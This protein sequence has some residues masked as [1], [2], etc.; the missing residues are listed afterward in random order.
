M[1][2]R[3][4][5]QGGL[6]QRRAV[7]QLSAAAL[8][9][10]VVGFGAFHRVDPAPP[11]QLHSTPRRPA[12]PQ[13][14][15]VAG[16]TA[17]ATP[18]PPAPSRDGG[19]G[20]DDDGDPGG[21]GGATAADT[22]GG[23]RCRITASGAECSALGE[24]YSMDFTRCSSELRLRSGMPVESVTSI[25]HGIY[26]VVVPSGGQFAFKTECRP[27]AKWH[28]QQGWPEVAVHQL[29][30]ALL[31]GND[32]VPCAA[33][34]V[35]RLDDRQLS[36]LHSDR[37]GVVADK[38]GMVAGV[39]M[40]W[41]TH[42]D[43]ALSSPEVKN[44]WKLFAPKDNKRIS[45]S[46]RRLA[47]QMGLVLALDFLVHNPDREEKNWFWG[48]GGSRRLLTMD[49]GWAFV[50][51]GYAGS[52]CDSAQESYLSCP[53]VIRHTARLKGQQGASCRGGEL[54]WCLW[55]PWLVQRMRGF[56]EAWGGG[57]GA[58]WE[59]G[60]LRDPLVEWLIRAYNTWG[61]SAPGHK[62]PSG[63]LYSTALGRF[64]HKCPGAPRAAD[65]KSA[66]PPQPAELAA[67]LSN[68]VRDR[69]KVLLAHVD[70]C[71]SRHGAA[72]VFQAE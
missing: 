63:R 56:A 46:G 31:G 53:P 16:A 70:K 18:L 42:R 52:V 54:Q 11:P 9:V 47:G 12:P 71:V 27:A 48:A 15:A 25:H 6:S 14:A 43:D 45:P 50:G 38:P 49:N 4:P 24:K 65:A 34:A 20:G 30:R 61:T 72:Y 1:R 55:S 60:L 19:G 22:G 58:A 36:R 13:G 66:P 29:S 35:L 62:T 39:A 57:L 59:R 7:L 10:S 8:A 26:K 41:T 28:G 23:G 17:E 21:E 68:G 40:R 5:P 33:G 37:C 64:V 32:T 67:W 51:S 2:H 44:A 3:A 69:L